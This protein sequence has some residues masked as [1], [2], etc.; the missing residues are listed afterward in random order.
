V[1]TQHL[2]TREAAEALGIHQ[3]TVLRAIQDGRIP[4]R[5]IFG[6]WRI[7]P[8]HLPTVTIP[9]PSALRPAPIS[10]R[11]TG[12]CGHAGRR[13]AGRKDSA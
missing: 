9:D 3:K 2:T 12:P 6:R 4:A 5:K 13:V 11:A 8:D 7:D 10:P 1:S